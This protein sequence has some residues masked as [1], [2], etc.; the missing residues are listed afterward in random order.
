LFEASTDIVIVV[1]RQLGQ[2]G[3][4]STE[5]VAMIID[6]ASLLACHRR[7]HVELSGSG[8]EQINIAMSN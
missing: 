2:Q 4:S 6:E 1:D 5:A 3:H 7:R 8:V